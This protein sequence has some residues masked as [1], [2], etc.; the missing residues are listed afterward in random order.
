MK[1]KD[2][3]NKTPLYCIDAETTMQYIQLCEKHLDRIHGLERENTRLREVVM[4]AVRERF[5]KKEGEKFIE[6]FLLT[7]RTTIMP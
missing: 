3:T 7:P 2:I 6:K 5:P 1:K 4:T